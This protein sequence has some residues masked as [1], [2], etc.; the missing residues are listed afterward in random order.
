MLLLTVA[1]GVVGLVLSGPNGTTAVS[2]AEACNL[3]DTPHDTLMTASAPGEKWRW[4]IRDS[5]PDRQIVIS[6][7]APDDSLIGKAEHIIKDRTR[8]TRRSTPTNPDVYGDWRV[9]GTNVPRAFSLPCVNPSS[10][11]EGTSGSSDEPDFTSEVFLSDEEG[12]MRNEY[13]VD[14]TGRP[15]RALRTTFPPEYDG[16]SNTDTGVIEFTYSGYD[17]ANVIE[18]PCAGAARDEADNPALMRDCIELLGLKDALRGTA[19][20]NWTLDTAMSSWDGITT[21]GEP[22]RITKVELSNESLSGS[23]PWELGKLSELTHLDLSNN[24]LTGEI[25]LEMG[26]LNN[27][28]SLKLS[29][30]T[31]TGCIPIALK[32]V[33]TNDLTSLNLLYCRPP[34][35]SAPTAG[36]ATLTSIPLSWTAAD[37]TS[38]YRVEYRDG[39]VGNWIVD[40]ESLT[41]TT[42]TVDDLR[43]GTAHQFRLSGYGSGTTYAAAWSDPSDTLT[44][45]TSMC[46][47]P[48]FDQDS[49]SF[50]VPEFSASGTVVGVASATDPN[51]DTLTY[52]IA[53][54]NEEGKFAINAT[55]GNI[56]VAGNLNYDENPKYTLSVETSDGTNT[57][58]VSVEINVTDVDP[59]PVFS[60]ESFSFSVNE[61][62]G[63]YGA[64]GYVLAKDPDSDSVTYSI[65]GGN[66]NGQFTID[67]NTGLILVRRSL[68]YDTRSSYTLT[69]G[70]MDQQNNTGSATVSIAVVETA[71]NPPPAP[72]GLTTV[73]EDVGNL[74]V[75]WNNVANASMYRLR[76]RTDPN[77]QWTTSAATANASLTF[78]S[79]TCGATYEFQA[80]AQGNGVSYTTGWSDP[81]ETVSR[82]VPLCPAP[83]YAATSYALNVAEDASVGAVVG[84]VAATHPDQTKLTYSITAG[85]EDG[86]FAIGAG[87]V[88]TLADELDHETTS[89]HTLTVQSQ[90][91]RGKTGT[92]TVS[93]TVTD[94]NEA[95]SFDAEEYTLTIAEDAA[96]GASAATVAAA[97]PDAND[98]LTYSITA[99]NDDGK[100]SIDGGGALSVAGALDYETTSSYALTVQAVD[101]DGLSDTAAVA[102]SVT[103]V[104]EA[105]ALNSEEYSFTVSEDVAISTAVGSVSATDPDVGDTL[106]FSIT[107]GDDDGKF[108]IDP[109]GSLSVAKA[110]DHET[111]A[112]YTLTVQAADPGSLSDTATVSVSVTDVNETPS[113]GAEEYTLTIAEDAATGAAVGTVAA[114]DPDEDAL[115]YSITAGNDDGKFRIDS[116]G[117]L[118]VAGALDFETT[119]SYAL[120]VQ[121]ADLDGLSDTAAVAVTVTDVNEAP[122]FGAATYTFTVSED[123]AI[124]TAVG[125][126]SA[127]DPDDGDTLTYSITD[128]NGDGKFA[129]NSSSGEIA[130]AA[131]LDY[132]T[133]TS[134]ALTVQ[135][136]DSG[137]LSGTATVNITVTNVAED[138]PTAPQRP[139]VSLSGDT[140]TISWN[141]VT[142]ADQYRVQHR[143]GGAESEWTNLDSTASTSQTFSP[144]GGAA[145]ETT[146]EFRVQA[147]GDGETYIVQWGAESQI[148]SHTTGTC[149]QAP[150]FVSA[151]YSFSASEDASTGT[152]VGTVAA[153][154]P[155]EGDT[156]SYSITAGNGDGKFSINAARE[157]LRWQHPWTLI[158]PPPTRSR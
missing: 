11:E 65:T 67:S 77:G 119:S 121:A 123:A 86:K 150:S 70:A 76:N 100:F 104:N 139:S 33:A 28:E 158:R 3:M 90:E 75:S 87:G 8:Y 142:G 101:P 113:F 13:W 19:A 60:R 80:Q 97:D 152:A 12:A 124:S 43:C 47:A 31:L 42:H 116:R 68:D 141:A 24:S 16:V 153:S 157:A 131:S 122:S 5:G 10:F 6:V 127:I 137:S 81:S 144:K 40:D 74:I 106:T 109:S 105:P 53:S 126:V 20:L 51:D 66:P 133:T 36:T 156:V 132:E 21:G 1:F 63:E 29:G 45:S 110:L 95:P 115:T 46:V 88:I 57:T 48:V 140:F 58:S 52:S 96:I 93:I 103:D 120:T 78:S 56:T 147:R 89:V 32:D 107:A 138:P 91:P 49:F 71:E 44:A 117:S 2:A 15:T 98:T 79:V 135:A 146:Y 23:I 129:I 143:N 41:G 84:T 17:E 35:P 25:P 26:R 151:T 83:V 38:K 7:T 102:V 82:A 14:S 30:N 112:S 59:P 114:A 149:N 130:I 39:T 94:V 54:G 148:A 73:L 4:E 69:V 154:D 108:S 128:G 136:A 18:A 118:L 22:S 134:Y 92:A 37:N 72:L 85:N 99:G 9:H 27:L 111:A 50:S 145:C 55:T 62:V 64:V 155:N 34:A 125:T 61:S